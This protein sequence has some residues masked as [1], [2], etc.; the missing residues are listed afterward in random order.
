MIVPLVNDEYIEQT[1]KKFKLIDM[2]ESYKSLIEEAATTNME[3]REFLIKLLQ[4]EESGKRLRQQE[5]LTKRAQF[6]MT[7]SLEDIDYGFNPS[8]DQAK[9]D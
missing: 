6:N 3:Y 4:S 5:R 2:R 8:L 7:K 1:M 9:I